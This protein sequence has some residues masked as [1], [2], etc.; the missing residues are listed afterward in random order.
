MHESKTLKAALD[1]LVERIA[2]AAEQQGAPLSQAERGM[3]H[4]SESDPVLAGHAEMSRTFEA[5]SSDEDFERR[6]AELVSQIHAENSKDPRK[7]RSWNQALEKLSEGDFYLLAILGDCTLGSVGRPTLG[8]FA[9]TLDRSRKRPPHDILTLILASILIL[10]GFFGFASLWTALRPQLAPWLAI[11]LDWLFTHGR[12]LYLV[13]LA[14]LAWQLGHDVRKPW[15]RFWT[16]PLRRFIELN[17]RHSP[18]HP[19]RRRS[20]D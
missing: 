14:V 10:F 12:I 5:S 8:G 15:L 2:T 19:R 20:A 16:D 4:F 6:I 17:P 18:S 3:L 11:Q 9:P 7:L 13:F 1:L